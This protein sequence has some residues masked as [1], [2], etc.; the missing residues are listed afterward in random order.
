MVTKVRVKS[1]KMQFECLF[2]V[3]RKILIKTNLMCFILE[4]N[5]K[6]STYKFLIRIRG[7][8]MKQ[9]S[10]ACKNEIPYVFYGAN[11]VMEGSLLPLVI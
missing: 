4:T 11:K 10:K 9:I 1:K 5:L 3:S 2:L 6:F 7:V 8:Y